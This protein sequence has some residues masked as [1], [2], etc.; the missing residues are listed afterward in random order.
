MNTLKIVFAKIIVFLFIK[1]WRVLERIILRRNLPENSHYYL[2]KIFHI[3]SGGS[4]GVLFSYANPLQSNRTLTMPLDLCRNNELWIFRRGSSYDA[5]LIKNLAANLDQADIFL[6]IG[7]NVGLYS[8]TLAQVFPKKKV[9]AVEPF[10]HNLAVLKKN[11]ELNHLLNIEVVEGVVSHEDGQVTFHVNPLNEGGGSIQSF[12]D[13]LTGDVRVNAE[14]FQKEHPDFVSK[15][16]VKSYRLEQLV[17]APNTCVFKIDVEGAEADVLRSAETIFRENRVIRLV[18][19]V[20]ESTSVD[21]I[22]FLNKHGFDCY[23]IGQ[24]S[25]MKASD[26]LPRRVVNLIG[27]KGQ[28]VPV[29][30]P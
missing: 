26:P 17:P 7:A 9:V 19:E 24:N 20:I 27:V 5:L 28:A 6:D 22:N 15:I 23:R 18:V 11:I 10:D 13:Y 21:V 8:L 4:Y 2:M 14:T 12:D 1:S 16:T 29:A 25:P 3:L 30:T